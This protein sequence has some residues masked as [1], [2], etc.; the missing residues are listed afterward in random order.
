MNE[1]LSFRKMITPA[2]IQIL[3]W[4]GVVICVIS[5]IAGI[6]ADA[7]ADIGGGKMV[8]LGFLMLILGPIFVRVYC[9][10]IIVM[11]RILDVL[12]DIQSGKK[13]EAASPASPSPSASE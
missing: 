12:K 1:Y 11:F 3:F 8:F 6:A 5:G 4:I 9:E 7:F 10:L 13:A 2:I